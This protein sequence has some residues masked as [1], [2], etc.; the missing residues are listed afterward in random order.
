MIEPPAWDR[1]S[2]LMGDSRGGPSRRETR[3]GNQNLPGHC[4]DI[5]SR[6]TWSLR[7]AV[8][9]VV[10][11]PFHVPSLFVREHG[12]QHSAFVWHGAF[13]VWGCSRSVS[14]MQ[15]SV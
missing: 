1:R 4:G 3:S 5:K 15:P 12:K 7:T 13:D 11:S 9:A 8:E 6:H 10:E 2:L 14:G